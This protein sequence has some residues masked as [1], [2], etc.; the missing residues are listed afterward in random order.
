ML[1][2]KTILPIITYLRHNFCLKF[3]RFGIMTEATGFRVD[4]P[5]PHHYSAREMHKTFRSHA[6][7]NYREANNLGCT[8]LSPNKKRDVNA[9]QD[10][11]PQFRISIIISSKDP[12]ISGSELPI[13]LRIISRL[14]TIKIDNISQ[15]LS[16]GVRQEHF[17]FV[18]EDPISRTPRD[19][20][21]L[22][23]CSDISNRCYNS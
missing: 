18:H 13:S 1:R 12:E 10:I 4:I 23:Y 11:N 2:H 6:H 19:P 5:F 21:C 9:G 22:Q 15:D 14:S 8:L 7:Q 20:L 16:N 17:L 3:D